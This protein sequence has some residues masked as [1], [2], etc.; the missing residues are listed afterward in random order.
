VDVDAGRPCR[1]RILATR[2]LLVLALTAT[3]ALA[4]KP[5]V[6]L[7]PFGH[8]DLE[9]QLRGALCSDLTCVPAGAVTVKGRLDWR[10]VSAEELTGVVKAKIARDANRRR[11]LDVEVFATA[12][13]ILVRR[14][15]PLSGTAMSTATLRGLQADLVGVI[16]RAHGPGEERAPAVAPVVPPPGPPLAAT[17]VPPPAPLPPSAAA[18]A[19]LATA[20]VTPAEAAPAISGPPA[21]EQAQAER[22]PPL[23][24]VQPTLGLLHR[25][26]EVSGGG[27]A[28]P[29]LRS[30]SVPTTAQPGLYLAVYPLRAREGFFSSLGLEGT[31]SASVGLQVARENDPAGTLFPATSFGASVALRLNLRLGPA[32]TLGP[33]VGWQLYNFDV[34]P[35]ASGEVLTGQPAVHWRALAPGLKLDVALG[36]W[37]LFLEARY[38]YVYSLGP[39]ESS[40]AFTSFSAAPSFDGT[41]GFRVHLTPE[42]QLRLA[43]AYARY[44]IQVPAGASSSQLTG[45]SDQLLGG[46]L[47][48]RYSL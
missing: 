27:G 29:V 38:L 14:K 18:A 47:S 45:L 2:A 11:I 5:R 37:G 46:T 1:G 12:K 26:F 33:V 21:V 19:P 34:H 40:S 13:V 30:T 42:V 41:V 43:F 31:V 17:V 3:P 8:A 32:V 25:S 44:A 39:L 10:K 24:D 23:L 35:A 7:L 20:P 22:G 28:A 15:V 9:R 6:T 36:R 16:R 4:E 48:L